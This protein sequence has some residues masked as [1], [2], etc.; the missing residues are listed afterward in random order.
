MSPAWLPL[1]CLQAASL[2][3]FVSCELEAL[4]L[5]ELGIAAIALPQ[6]TP[7]WLTA[8][9]MQRHQQVARQQ[10]AVPQQLPSEVL[11]LQQQLLLLRWQQQHQPPQ[12]LPQRQHMHEDPRLRLSGLTAELAKLKRQQELG[13]IKQASQHVSSSSSSARRDPEGLLVS[14]VAH[15]AA[16]GL[17]LLLPAASTAVIAMTQGPVGDAVGSELAAML[18]EVSCRHVQWPELTPVD[19]AADALEQVRQQP[20][21]QQGQLADCEAW[22]KELVH[23][24]AVRPHKPG[25]DLLLLRAVLGR[26]AVAAAV[27]GAYVWPIM[28]LE[29]FSDHALEL[30][31][32][33]DTPNMDQIAVSTGWASLDG[34]Y[35]VG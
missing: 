5:S 14:G 18:G 15:P 11:P 16:S 31:T 34:L 2:V 32:Y 28:G 20:A 22:H 3:V 26:D 7:T 6:Q 13:S 27:S 21:G 12:Q 23:A 25:W 29:R 10:Q 33:Y 17:T 1:L 4:L 8:D 19:A 35:K 24:A 9:S 30:L